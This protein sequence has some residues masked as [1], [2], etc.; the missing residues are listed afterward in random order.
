KLTII[1]L[2]LLL[3]SALVF[4]GGYEVPFSKGEADK[5]YCQFNS[6][7]TLTALTVDNLTIINGILNIVNVTLINYNVTGKINVEGNI[8][9]DCITLSDGTKF[10]DSFSAGLLENSTGEV[11]LKTPQDVNYNKNNLNNA[12]NIT[13]ERINATIITAN[14]YFGNGSELTLARIGNSTFST[15]QDLQNIYHS[16]G[17]VTGGNITSN[18]THINVSEGTGLIRGVDNR[19]ATIFYFDWSGTTDI[20]IPVNTTRYVGIEYNAGSP[21][22]VIKTT[23]TWDFQTDFPIGTV[24]QEDTGMHILLNPQAI[25]D[26]ATFMIRRSYE[27]G[28]FA[29]DARTGGLIIGTKGQNITMTAGNIWDR[30]NVF[31]LTSKDTGGSDTMDRYYR[32]G[33][34]G[35]RIEQGLTQ[36]NNS[37]YDDG[38]GTLAVLGNNKYAVQWFYIEVDDELVSMYGTAQYNVLAAAEDEGV[39]ISVPDRLSKH[40]RLIGRIIFQEGATEASSVE[41]VFPIAFAGAVVTDHGDLAGLADDD[42][43]QY[44]LADGT[45]ALT[46]TWGVG[47]FSII[48]VLEFNGTRL[49]ISGGASIGGNVG[50]GTTSPDTAFHIKADVP[51]VVG[52]SFAGQ[53]II[54]NPADNNKSNV[55]ITAYE[56]DGNGN[57]DQQLWY[58]GSSSSS[59]EDI[60]LLNRRNAKLHLG[61]SGSTRMTIL[62]NGSVGIGTMNPTAKL[63]ISTLTGGEDLLFLRDEINTADLTIDS[64][65]GALMEIRAG[66]GDHLQLSSGATANQGIRIRNDGNV[67]IGTANP[68]SKLHVVGSANITETITGEQITST[69]DITAQGTVFSDN[70]FS[71]DGFGTIALGIDG[72]ITL[73]YFGSTI[74]DCSIFGGWCNFGGNAI[75]TTST[76]TFQG[77]TIKTGQIVTSGSS[78]VLRGQASGTPAINVGAGGGIS[79][80]APLVSMGGNVTLKADNLPISF[81]VTLTDLQISSDGTHPVYFATGVHTFYNGTVGS[82]TLGTVRAGQYIT[83]SYVPDTKSNIDFLSKLDNIDSWKNQDGTI[84]YNSHYA[85]V[86]VAVKDGDNCEQVIDKYCQFRDGWE[87][88]EDEIPEGDYNI[89]YKEECGTKLVGGLDLGKMAGDSLGMINEL[90]Q[91]LQAKDIII[92][93]ICTE[94][95]LKYNKYDWCNKI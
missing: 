77:V 54:Q 93:N 87:F 15:V 38:S 79:L 80:N 11:R 12:S 84:N 65:T 24:I 6:I 72:S 17:W 78:L 7:C 53:I 70:L 3:A 14:T 19:T 48:D 44:L 28:P 34:G 18:N 31:P 64:P 45:R 89:T 47:G 95:N 76:G 59:T 68:T 82:P 57:P 16:V 50:I 35:F 90:K 61:T 4:A 91:E 66:V 30:L 5:L 73:E 25:G 2:G 75:T 63:H 10:C 21:Q 1:I 9:A 39:P 32:N 88:C 37:K 23:D 20:L 74:M 46:G 56:S 62:G 49:N 29:R 13:T 22:V 40:G 67:G 26:H 58:L 55:V 8:T 43:T 41:S 27:T 42:H 85:G 92:Q 52:S 36:W 60:I 51:G 69:D 71:V 86:K 83:G 33:G 94:D 81:G